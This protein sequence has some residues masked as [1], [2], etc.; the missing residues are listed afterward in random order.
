MNVELVKVNTLLNLA[1]IPETVLQDLLLCHLIPVVVRFKIYWLS[2]KR[3]SFKKILMH[4]LLRIQLKLYMCQLLFLFL[5][6]ESTLNVYNC[7]F[8]NVC[9]DSNL[10][11]F[12]N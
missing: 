9:H 6:R 7:K 8:S 1:I 2:L 4:V 3:F 11:N 10:T 12:M 5:N